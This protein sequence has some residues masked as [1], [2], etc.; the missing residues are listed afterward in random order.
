MAMAW[1]SEAAD[2]HSRVLAQCF[3]GAG[4]GV[5]TFTAQDEDRI[6]QEA[7]SW[8]VYCETLAGKA[9]SLGHEGCLRVLHELGGEAA[10]SLAAAGA[11]G[12]TPAHCAAYQEHGGCLRVLDEGGVLSEEAQ[13]V[14]DAASSQLKELSTLYENFNAVVQASGG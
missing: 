6:W 8:K 11:G 3:A 4:H 12:W 7:S 5:E 13:Y 9:A 2:E 1:R 14:R 10:A